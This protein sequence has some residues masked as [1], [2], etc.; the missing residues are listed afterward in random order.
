MSSSSLFY[1]IIF[2]ILILLSIYYFLSSSLSYYPT[3]LLY[4]DRSVSRNLPL[5]HHRAAKLSF[6]FDFSRFFILQIFPFYPSLSLTPLP[7]PSPLSSRLFSFLVFVSSRRFFPFVKWKRN[8]CC[9]EWNRVE[10][11]FRHEA[12]NVSLICLSSLEDHLS[13]PA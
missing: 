1:S 8:G 4:V 13:S 2:Q 10:R 12:S 6:F 7:P 9:A 11:P 3:T 5:A